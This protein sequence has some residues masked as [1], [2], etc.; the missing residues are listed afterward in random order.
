MGNASTTGGL[1]TS[2]YVEYPCRCGRQQTNGFIH[3]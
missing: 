1:A 3:Q 2:H